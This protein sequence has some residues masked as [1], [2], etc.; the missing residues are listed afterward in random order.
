[1]IFSADGRYVA[2]FIDNHYFAVWNVETGKLVAGIQSSENLRE[3]VIDTSTP[4]PK[5]RLEREDGA[6][7]FANFTGQKDLQWR[8]I[9]THKP[10]HNAL[11]G[12]EYGWQV[13]QGDDKRTL[14]LVNVDTNKEYPIHLPNPIDNWGHFVSISANG[15]DLLLNTRIPL[16]RGKVYS[17]WKSHRGKDGFKKFVTISRAWFN[18]NPVL[19]SKDAACVVSIE[20]QPVRVVRVYS[21]D[22]R[23]STTIDCTKEF[24]PSSNIMQ[25]FFA[26]SDDGKL[27]AFSSSDFLINIYSTSTSSRQEILDP[28]EALKAAGL[29]APPAPGHIEQIDYFHFNIYNIAISPNK[30][31]LCAQVAGHPVVWR[32]ATGKAIVLEQPA[33]TPPPYTGLRGIG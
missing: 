3:A 17:M 25:P 24:F 9:G 2:D 28:R 30:S 20:E 23:Q 16:P 4:Q 31:M 7:A 1:M 10:Y 32:I 18:N 21:K 29:D 12:L 27:F 22:T 14:Y 26:L 15:Q 13:Q 6:I 33:Y 19:M 8:K 5:V 11:N